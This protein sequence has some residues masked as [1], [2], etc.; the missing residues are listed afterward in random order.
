MC[1]R[2]CIY[3]Y[4]HIYTYVYI[5]IYSIYTLYIYIYIYIYIYM[6]FL[7]TSA[8]QRGEGRPT[9]KADNTEI[10][11]V[12]VCLFAVGYVMLFVVL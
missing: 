4:I 9:R 6:F 11:A 7:T 10:G 12:V 2:I 1:I 5:Y 3:I 8:Q